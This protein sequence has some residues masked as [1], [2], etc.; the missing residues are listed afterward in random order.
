[1]SLPALNEP[2]PEK[3]AAPAANKLLIAPS[4]LDLFFLTLMAWLFLVPPEGWGR[5]LEDG[6]IGWHIR[7]GEWILDHKSIPREDLFSFTR[8]GEPWFAWEWGAELI[9][10]LLYRGWGLK[11]IVLFSGA[12]IALFGAILVRYSLWRGANPLLAVCL[13]FAGVGAASVHFLARPHLYTLILV[14][15][16]LWMLEADRRAPGWYLW[17]L[18]PLTAVWVNLHGGF[19]VVP[20]MAGLMAAGV[21]AEEWWRQG[22]IAA[23]VRPAARYALLAC[24]C[25]LA[26][27]M[28]PYGLAL[29]AHAFSHLSAGWIQ[30]IV[31]EFQPPDFRRENAQQFGILLLAGLISI[32][33]ML[34]RRLVTESLWLLFWAQQSLGSVRHITV[35]V[36]VAAPVAGTELSRIWATW[37]RHGGPRS[38]RSALEGFAADLKAGCSRSTVWPAAIIAIVLVADIPLGWPA[39]FPPH[40]FPIAE[41]TR[42]AA[43]LQSHRVYTSDEWADYLVFRNWPRQ[44]VF[45][46][47]RIDFYGREIGR[48]ALDLSQ[49]RPGW[50][51]TLDGFS[52][53][54][55]LAEP[56]W[57][58]TGRLRQDSGWEIVEESG[59][60]VI[61][62]RVGNVA[63]NNR[64]S[65]AKFVGP[66]TNGF[67]QT[68]RILLGRAPK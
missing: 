19:L 64:G 45:I 66:G 35:F 29:H 44:R 14:P 27:A 2:A 4:L 5:L 8:P 65:A 28:N 34:R 33:M 37:V 32:P 60:A 54:V 42:H 10:G 55:V 16:A 15:I 17:L 20:L 18:A 25:T 57:P 13:S 58:L 11:G 53:E 39:D 1:M 56:A 43:F 51:D 38:I 67:I 26:S 59:Q 40:R 23:A 47:G 31:D 41:I 61:F 63:D 21:V 68:D 48:K 46:D 9:Y 62:Q 3:T 24:A 36:A 6:D 7:V 49:A 30:E 52:V 22:S 50:G 12:Q